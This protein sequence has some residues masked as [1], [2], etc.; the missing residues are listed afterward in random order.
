M[1]DTEQLE[2]EVEVDTEERIIRLTG[3]ITEESADK[4]IRSLHELCNEPGEIVQSVLLVMNGETVSTRLPASSALYDKIC[5][6]L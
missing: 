1:D 2:V 4:C 6:N 5:F 3:E